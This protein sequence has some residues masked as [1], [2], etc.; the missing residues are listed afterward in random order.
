[1]ETFCTFQKYQ[2][3]SK[4]IKKKVR[5]KEIGFE[6]WKERRS[7]KERRSKNREDKERGVK[8]REGVD[9]ATERKWEGD[10]NTKASRVVKIGVNKIWRYG[11]IQPL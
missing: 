11:E 6:N 2:S 7:T 3:T 4:D 1:M 5:A 8:N 10:F 9:R